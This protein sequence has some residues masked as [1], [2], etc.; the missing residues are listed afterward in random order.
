M[1]AV[2]AQRENPSKTERKSNK[3]VVCVVHVMNNNKPNKDALR[4]PLNLKS[5]HFQVLF[6]HK[7]HKRTPKTIEEKTFDLARHVKGIRLKARNF[8][9]LFLNGDRFS[10]KMH[11]QRKS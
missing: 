1:C 4:R 7:K 10:M 6:A 9:H 11:F 8:S 3:I 5:K 2:C